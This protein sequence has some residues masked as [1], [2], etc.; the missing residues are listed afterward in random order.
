MRVFKNI[1]RNKLD[2]L[3]IISIITVSL[4][5]VNIIFNILFNG[6]VESKQTEKFSNKNIGIT[7]EFSKEISKNEI[8][9]IMKKI[10][11]NNIP[12]SFSKRTELKGKLFDTIITLDSVNSPDLYDYK[13]KQGRDITTDDIRNNRKVIVISTNYKEFFYE[14]EGKYFISIDGIE[15][16]IIGVTENNLANEWY[17]LKAFTPYNFKNGLDVINTNIISFYTDKDIKIPKSISSYI[18]EITYNKLNKVTVNE[19]IET[20][21]TEIGYYIILGILSIVN[22]CIFFILFIKKR[23]P[24]INILRAVGYNKKQAGNYILKQMLV[25]G[26][27]SSFIA[28]GIYYPF[29]NYFNE[30]FMNIGLNPS[31]L[32]LIVDFLFSLIVIFIISKILFRFISNMEIQEGI[33]KRKNILN[34]MFIKFFIIIELFMMFNYS[35][36]FY[37]LTKNL[38]QILRISNRIIDFDNTLIMDGFSISFDSEDL[39]NYDIINTIKFLE[40]NGV[41]VVNYLYSIDTSED[42]MNMK[43]K[44]KEG[45]SENFKLS[46]M[47][48]EDNILPLMYISNSSLDI[49]K[50]KGIEKQNNNVQSNEVLVYAGESYKNYFKEGDIIKGNSGENYKIIGF[51]DENQYMFNTNQGSKII[52]NFN[53]L[54]SFIIVPFEINDLDN[55]NIAGLDLESKR[56][57]TLANSFIKFSDESEKA[58][59]NETL[60]KKELKADSLD[61]QLKRMQITDFSYVKY[62]LFSAIMISII[63]LISL[64]C[65][66]ISLIYSERRNMG[67]K[68]AL[69]YNIINIIKIYIFKIISMIAI[70]NILII[71]YKVIREDVFMDRNVIIPI[72]VIDIFIIVLSLVLIIYYVRREKISELIKEKD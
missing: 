64:I 56:F 61:I 34:N 16:E 8:N 51:I 18:R 52:D 24:I 67:I 65:Y 53:K 45:Y 2:F 54:D 43:N 68:R 4:I 31:I 35:I 49:L 15:Y 27:I 29:S 12:F 41:E 50:I 21:T 23:K 48:L 10:D 9:E 33:K 14:K 72:V 37:S 36:E 46:F 39:K 47:D 5:G 26:L 59:I 44:E 22:L 7:L 6:Y 58:L 38:S 28:W 63:T 62:K 19:I 20:M 42:V 30:K 66:I 71:V 57:Y 55:I 60:N 13:I 32:I 25:C 3:V 17:R 69:G 11:E 1:F 40:Q 70:S